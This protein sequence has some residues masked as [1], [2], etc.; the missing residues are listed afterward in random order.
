MELS[1][2]AESDLDNIRRIGEGWVAE[3]TLGIA[4][5]CALRHHGPAAR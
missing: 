5:Y 1:E 4:I 3:E 2:N